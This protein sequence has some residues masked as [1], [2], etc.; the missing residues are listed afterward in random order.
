[1][2]KNI[3]EPARVSQIEFSIF[4]NEVKNIHKRAHVFDEAFSASFPDET[5]TIPSPEEAPPN[6]PRIYV[7]SDNQGLVISAVEGK[8]V[9]REAENVEDAFAKM[10]NLAKKL[11]K[12]TLDNDFMHPTSAKIE[13]EVQYPLLDKNFAITNALRNKYSTGIVGKD[14]MAFAISFAHLDNDVYTNHSIGEYRVSETSDDNGVASY[15]ENYNSGLLK[16]LDSQVLKEAG[17]DYSLSFAKRITGTSQHTNNNFI[18]F[19]RHAEKTAPQ[20]LSRF[21]AEK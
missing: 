2:K 10:D 12:T 18:Q 15:D 11:I 7:S 21:F 1:M 20:I 19:I 9:V 16:Y 6:F 5:K 3:F 14:I 17:V 8:V 4:F 13:I